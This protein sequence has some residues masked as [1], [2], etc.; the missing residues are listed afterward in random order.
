MENKGL[1]NSTNKSHPQNSAKKKIYLHISFLFYVFC[2]LGIIASISIFIKSILGDTN[3]SVPVTLT[4]LV[5]ASLILWLFVYIYSISRS[6]LINTQIQPK[7]K[8]GFLV[9]LICLLFSIFTNIHLFA[10]GL[11]WSGSSILFLVSSNKYLAYTQRAWSEKK[12]IASICLTAITFDLI[13]LTFDLNLSHF[14]V[15]AVEHFIIALLYALIICVWV[16][17]PLNKTAS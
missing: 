1:D 10:I 16:Y 11:V 15:S 13:P 12:K 6:G 4:P 14:K 7:P 17:I 5:A 9:G 2:S 8:Y 3:K